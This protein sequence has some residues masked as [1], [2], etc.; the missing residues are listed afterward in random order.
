MYELIHPMPIFYNTGQPLF[1]Q[2]SLMH[3][4]LARVR[5]RSTDHSACSQISRPLGHSVHYLFTVNTEKKPY[6]HFCQLWH[7][8]V[9][10][11]ERPGLGSL[12]Q[13]GPTLLPSQE[14]LLHRPDATLG[15]PGHCNIR[16]CA[17]FSPWDTSPSKKYVSFGQVRSNQV[18]FNFFMT[19]NCPTAN[20][21]ITLEI[22]FTSGHCN[23]RN[24]L[25]Y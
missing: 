17:G 2:G 13:R 11:S 7:Y 22:F 1:L 12:L 8:I 18:G 16:A 3:I 5:S 15:N 21:I 19:A 6:P 4:L 23:I 20:S 9:V 14:L 24:M 25:H 10:R